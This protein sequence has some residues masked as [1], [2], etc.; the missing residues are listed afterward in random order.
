MFYFLVYLQLGSVFCLITYTCQK[1]LSV[2]IREELDK[3]LNVINILSENK[4]KLNEQEIAK[5]SECLKAA[6][7]ILLAAM[8]YERRSYF[9]FIMTILFWPVV[10]YPEINGLIFVNNEFKN[11]LYSQKKRLLEIKT[12]GFTIIQN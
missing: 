10:F 2:K 5:V 1:K 7:P 4:N 6:S 9:S 3:F 11:I 12:K 8:Y